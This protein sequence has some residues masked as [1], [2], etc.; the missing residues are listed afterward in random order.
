MFVNISNDQMQKT[1]K[2]S[3]TDTESFNA[4]Y[5]VS[6]IETKEE[7]YNQLTLTL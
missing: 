5:F 4:K 1:F 7:N 3:L 2:K 6:F